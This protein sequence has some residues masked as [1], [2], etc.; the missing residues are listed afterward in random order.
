MKL[1]NNLRALQHRNFR[2]FLVGQGTSQIGNW[3]QLIATSWL[4]Y[5]LS[6]STLM[7]GLAAFSLQIPMLVITPFAGVLLDRLDVRRVLFATNTLAMLQSLV[8]LSLMVSGHIETWHVVLGNAIL[9]LGNAFDAPA[10]QA[11]ISKLLPDR[12]ELTNAI[13][14]NSTVMNGAR[15]IG[16]ML[17]GLVA[18]AF[19]EVWSF[20]VNSVMRLAVLFALRATNI[21]THVA[22]HGPSSILKQLMIG[23]EYA[24][25]FFPS[26]CALVLLAVSSFCLHS[27][28]SLMPWFASQRFHGDSKTLGLLYSSAGLGAVCGMIYLASRTN[29]R[30]LFKVIGWSAG[31]AGL[32]LVAFSFSESLWLAL[33]MLFVSSLSMMLTAASTNTVLQSIVPDELRGRVAALYVMSFLGMSPVGSLFSGWLA[34]H[35]GSQNALAIFGATGLSAALVYAYHFKQI[36]AEILPLYAALEMPP[37]DT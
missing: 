34:D 29:I 24:Y 28:G 12:Q 36:R 15:F 20:A 18:A 16:P 31:V 11:L 21:A 33:P 6:G 22:R 19:G 2:L 27:Y 26:R 10:R 3:V 5:Q 14:L 25:G 9:G 7:L 1:P 4:V 17:G 23:I 32:T 37:Y 8:M 35:I 30:G 13:A